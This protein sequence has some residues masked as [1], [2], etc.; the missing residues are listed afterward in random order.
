MAK[1]YGITWWGQQWLNALSNI[2]NSNRLPRGRSYANTGKVRSTDVSGNRI[3]AKVQGTRPKPYKIDITVPL[4]A[5]DDKKHLVD[6]VARNPAL[7]AQLLNRE[8]PGDLLQFAE[9]Q[10]IRVFPRTWRDFGM[11]CS[12]PD[13][14]VPCKH[15]A[16]VIYT[17]AEEIDRNPFLVFELHGLDL[18]KEL[19]GRNIC[20]DGNKTE[21]ITSVESLLM[22]SPAARQ[23]AGTK[24]SPVPK[25]GRGNQKP[26]AKKRKSKTAKTAGEIPV[27]PPAIKGRERLDFTTIPDVGGQISTLFKPQPLFYEK[28]FKAIIGK[29]YRGTSRAAR[30]LLR[31]DTVPTGERL[32]LNLSDSL[33]LV[34]DKNL[35]LKNIEATNKKGNPKPQKHAGL[36]GLVN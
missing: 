14:A 16:A 10:G 24:R 4:F 22:D 26:E 6:E 5:E 11:E 33:H 7:V 29:L 17:V 36:R 23:P 35:L 1:K 18:V 8:L 28:D 9:N 30:K 32:D 15:L 13:W 2:D 25:A 20:I 3:A 31:G 27:T 19:E 34:F 21:R 12:C